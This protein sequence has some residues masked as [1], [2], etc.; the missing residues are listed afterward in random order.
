MRLPG[1]PRSAPVRS[2][3]LYLWTFVR[4][5]TPPLWLQLGQIASQ[6]LRSQLARFP[7]SVQTAFRM[8]R[9]KHRLLKKTRD[10]PNPRDADLRTP[11][12]KWVAPAPGALRRY[13]A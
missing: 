12:A 7:R 5:M 13:H 6:G 4:E 1:Y 10:L 9:E 11:M 2:R 8:L 3:Y